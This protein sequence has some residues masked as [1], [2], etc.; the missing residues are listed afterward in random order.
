MLRANRDT[1]KEWTRQNKGLL[2]TS[3][4]D[5]GTTV[6]MEVNDLRSESEVFKEL[7]SAG[8]LLRPDRFSGWSTIAYGLGL[9]TG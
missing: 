6:V 9:A 5:E 3:P 4:P 1:V 8:V 7:R 2:S